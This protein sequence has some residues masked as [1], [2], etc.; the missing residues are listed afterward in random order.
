MPQQTNNSNNLPQSQS[1]LN[2]KDFEIQPESVELRT[3]RK[4]AGRPAVKADTARPVE[5][6]TGTPKVVVPGLGGVTLVIH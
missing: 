1:N 5:N 2:P 3:R 4:S 6:G